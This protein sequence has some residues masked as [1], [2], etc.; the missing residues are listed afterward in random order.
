MSDLK[1]KKMN[2]DRVKKY[3]NVHKG[4]ETDDKKW[5]SQCKRL[6]LKTNFTD[7]YKTCL[8]HPKKS[9]NI[10]MVTFGDILDKKYNC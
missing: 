7:K 10:K 3:R 1:L 6:R 2:Q 5:C 4:T 8:D 9:N